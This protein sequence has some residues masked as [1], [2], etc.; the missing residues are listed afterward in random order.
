MGCE[1]NENDKINEYINTLD[2]NNFHNEINLENQQ[3]RQEN[4]FQMILDELENMMDDV[5][6]IAIRVEED[7]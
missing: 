4:I 1:T 2:E 6:Y 5:I 7:N 3:D